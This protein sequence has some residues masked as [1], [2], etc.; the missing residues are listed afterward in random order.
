MIRFS[1]KMEYAL[2]AMLYISEK[3][4]GE[5]TTAR[6]LS[7]SF[8]TPPEL[9]GKVLQNLARNGLITS[10]QGVKGGYQI[11]IPLPDIKISSI[12]SAMEGPIHLVS[13]SI[14]NSKDTCEQQRFCNIKNSVTYIQNK[15]TNLFDNIS[16]K[17]LQNLNRP[18]SQSMYQNKINQE[19]F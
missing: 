8:N 17:D 10:V 3:N 13:C 7:D 19:V 16:L 2:I 14:P 18:V 15:I 4:S 5:L 9:M 11:D 1:K 6:E 12:I